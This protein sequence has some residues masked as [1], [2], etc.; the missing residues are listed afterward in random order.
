MFKER[1][2]KEIKK[3]K[4]KAVEA[5][6]KNRQGKGHPH[7]PF[8]KEKYYKKVSQEERWKEDTKEK[9]ECQRSNHRCTLKEDKEH[10]VIK[11]S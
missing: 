9:E 10:Q 8:F 7:K 11:T 1:T 2:E 4:E 5:Y 3:E 6:Q